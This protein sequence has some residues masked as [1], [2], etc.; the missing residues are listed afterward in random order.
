MGGS[1]NLGGDVALYALM[2][3]GLVIIFWDEMSAG[4]SLNATLRTDRSSEGAI[5]F[6]SLNVTEMSL[7]TRWGLKRWHQ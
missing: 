1:H 7:A 2:A 5:Q 4:R 3:M 6:F